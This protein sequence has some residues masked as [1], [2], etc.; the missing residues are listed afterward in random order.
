[1]RDKRDQQRRKKGS[2]GCGQ[3]GLI[4][5]VV[6]L[7]AM[8]AA[9]VLGYA[10]GIFDDL[11]VKNGFLNPAP[12][13]PSVEG[14]TVEALQAS[15]TSNIVMITA[16]TSSIETMMP[17][18]ATPTASVTASSPVTPSQTPSI[19]PVPPAEVCAQL[20]LSFLNA[21]SNVATWRL[22]NSSGVSLE[23]ARI[24][25]LWPEANDA[26]FNTLMDGQVIWS[27]EDLD[28][29]TIITQWMG[30]QDDRVLAG[31]SR[32]EFFFGITAAGSGYHL[33]IGFTNGCEVST[34]N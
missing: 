8:S 33:T 3:M 29:P 11:L 18:L 14:S 31:T 23:V 13:T 21:T 4:F 9:V 10:L 27:G 17:T 28:S 1:M 12:N 6:V 16:T 19:T 32:L 7:L 24:E 26:I 22:Q 20:N 30:S 15:P 5:L 34:S 2:L 25:I